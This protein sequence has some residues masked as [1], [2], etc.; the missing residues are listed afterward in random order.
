MK[1]YVKKGFNPSSL[2][3]LVQNKEDKKEASKKSG[4]ARIKSYQWKL[5]VN[6]PKE[7]N[8][9][10]EKQLKEFEEV[11]ILCPL[12]ALADRL[13]YYWFYIYHNKDVDEKGEFKTPHYHI[14]LIDSYKIKSSKNAFLDLI[15]GEE[16]LNLPK[17]VITLDPI[18]RY[19]I[20]IRYLIHCDNNDRFQYDPD[21]IYTNR[22]EE[23]ERI[24]KNLT[25]FKDNLQ[26]RNY[27]TTDDL[28]DLIYNKKCSYVQ[29]CQLLDLEYIKKYN[30]IINTML[31]DR[32]SASY[33]NLNK[34]SKG[35]G[36]TD[37]ELSR[38]AY[39][40]LQEKKPWAWKKESKED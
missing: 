9:E 4:D 31:N 36:M 17:N 16:C 11:H 7:I 2:K 35:E 13:G 6:I 26:K 15:S 1:K 27:T 18:Y 29:L 5:I 19:E 21:K 40:R 37:E 14:R 38:R 20:D 3:N 28:I 32:N 8:V 10:D 23:K 33:V 34:L 12:I 25:L 30:T 39:S 24:I 22:S